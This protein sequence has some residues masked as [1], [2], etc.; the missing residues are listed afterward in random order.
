M[1]CVRAERT[2]PNPRGD[3]GRCCR[4]EQHI[5]ALFVAEVFGHRQARQR[6]TRPRARRLVHLAEDE[7]RLRQHA[8]VL[9]FD[10]HI[11]AFPSPLPHSREHRAAFVLV[12]DVADELLH[13][14]RLACA[15][16]TEQADL[17]TLGKC[18]DE[19]DDL[20]P[21]LEDL[22]LRLLFVQRRRGAVNRP[23]RGTFRRRLVVDGFAHHVEQP[24][25][26]LDSDR[27]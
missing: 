16:A 24:A 5:R 9:H 18:A 1:A 12:G 21:R 25:Q 11:V 15:G 10:V 14:D 19:V 26:R 22:D 17:R 4:R 3:S 23:A 7:S 20:D 2:P 6:H 8:R 13:D 27:H